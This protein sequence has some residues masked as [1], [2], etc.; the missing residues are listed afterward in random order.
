M[1][2]AESLNYLRFKN[3]YNI[4]YKNKHEHAFTEIILM[5]WSVHLFGYLYGIIFKVFFINNL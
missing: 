3:H 4:N 2:N 1:E 5:R